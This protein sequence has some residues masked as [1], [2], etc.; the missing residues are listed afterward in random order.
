MPE[1]FRK[2]L[3]V[4]S[5]TS[6]FSQESFRLD[7]FS[8]EDISDISNVSDYDGVLLNLTS[9][10]EAAKTK[11][12]EWS[13]LEKVFDPVAWADVIRCRGLI[14]VVGDPCCSVLV[15]PDEAE[16]DPTAEAHVIHFSPLQAL[17]DVK[18]D[19]RPFDF[20]RAIQNNRS[21]STERFYKYLDSVSAWAYSLAKADV[22]DQFEAALKRVN[23]PRKRSFACGVTRYGAALAVEYDFIHEEGHA[24]GALTILPPSGRGTD[25]EDNFILGEFFGVATALP[26]P[27]WVGK[28]RVS[29]QPEI[30]TRIA[31][32]QEAVR[33]LQQELAVDEGSLKNCRRWFRLLYD[34]GDSLEATVKESFEVLGAQVEK[35]SK[36]KE[37]YRVRVL[38]YPHAVMEVK[39]THNSKFKIPALRE[40]AHW[41]DEAN[42]AKS[43]P[44][45]GI[46]VGNGGRNDEPQNRGNLFEPNCEGYAQT[47]DIVILRTMDL[48]CLVVLKQLDRLETNGLWKGLFDCRGSFDA[49]PYLK[50]LPKEFQFQSKQKVTDEKPR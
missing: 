11:A 21:A 48:F 27:A 16:C 50:L 29:G 25:A 35:K 43:V 49:A 14:V 17:L 36:E 9:L 47:K 39:G 1:R 33:R 2:Y 40:L 18:T 34:D 30:E 24:V 10:E 23:I 28:L 6:R 5:E 13:H 32:K 26:E 19:N 7:R 44:V 41:M 45:K 4:S 12:I 38:G 15:E 37:D 20:R 46:F 22:T 31:E 3:C 42:A 8:W